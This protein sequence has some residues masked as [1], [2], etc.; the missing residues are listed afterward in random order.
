MAMNADRDIPQKTVTSK[1][2][3]SIKERRDHRLENIKIYDPPIITTTA[4]TPQVKLLKFP[5]MSIK[6]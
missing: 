3:Q 1:R 4:A 6:N 2:H 5:L